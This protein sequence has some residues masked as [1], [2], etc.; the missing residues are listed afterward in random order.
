MKPLIVGLNH[1]TAPVEVREK[2]AFGGERLGQG[3]EG[4]LALPEVLEVV[5]LST[6]NRVEMYASVTDEG[7]AAA[8]IMD[9]IA[10]FHGIERALLDKSLY[11]HRGRDAVR[12]AFRVAASLDSM[13]VGEAQILGQLK[14]AYEFSLGRKATGLMLNKLMKKSISVAKR[15]R[16]E[17]RISESAVN[18]SSVAVDLAR[19]IFTD[20]SEKSVL[21]LGAGDM[22][23]LAARHLITQG[24]RSIMVANRTHATGCALAT[25]IGGTAIPFEEF[26]EEMLRTDIVICSTGASH[27]V[28]SKD[29]MQS[30]MR[31]RRHK[32]MFIIDIAVPRNIDPAINNLDDVYLYDVDDL[33]QVADTNMAERQKEADKGEAIVEEEIESFLKWQGSLDATPTILALRTK[34]EEIKSAE[35]EKAFG[36]LPDLGERERKA[37]EQLA[38]AIVNK[39]VHPPTAALKQGDE[40]RDALIATIRRLYGLNGESDQ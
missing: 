13:V 36:R 18:I 1:T 19:K 26:M 28:V 24:V 16:T 31:A 37:M 20:L 29:H 3:V 14:D 5:V 27:Y 12:H 7:K 25:E 17:T 15:V 22:A 30:I 10:A 39:L 34:A 4:L 38:S 6:C 8:A 21:L 35:L 40:D 33:R 23:E 32:P 9:F 2:F 11:F